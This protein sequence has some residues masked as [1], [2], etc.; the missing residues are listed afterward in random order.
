[1][2]NISTKTIVAIITFLIGVMFV[3]FWFKSPDM[4]SIVSNIFTVS[5]KIAESE[6][7]EVY[8]VALNEVFSKSSSNF[9]IISDKTY[10]NLS[11]RLKPEFDISSKYV[12]IDKEKY[13]DSIPTDETISNSKNSKPD[14][15]EFF[16][17]YPKSLGIVRLS[18]IKYSEDKTKAEVYVELTYCPLCGFG[19][20]VSLEKKESSWKITN[21]SNSWIS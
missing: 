6:D 5:E 1:M 9:L 15:S 19:K 4:F 18:S 7:Y 3:V 20:Y 12:L 17:E 21:I 8:S 2:K 14:I 10:D 13:D 16:K 11:I